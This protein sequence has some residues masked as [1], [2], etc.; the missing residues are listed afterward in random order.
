MSDLIDTALAD[1]LRIDKWTREEL[2]N[3][4]ADEANLRRF[5]RR[6]S[7]LLKSTTDSDPHLLEDFYILG[8]ATRD[9]VRGPFP[10]DLEQINMPIVA[11]VYGFTQEPF[12]NV[13]KKGG[14]AEV[15]RHLFDNV[16][17]KQGIA[18][19]GK[20]SLGTGSALPVRSSVSGMTFVTVPYVRAAG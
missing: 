16:K 10:L 18:R 8:L 7:D 9:V 12:E 20:A 3:L 15:R 17:A 2:R 5:S 4:I 19:K 11:F 1:R 13:F 14:L 6:I